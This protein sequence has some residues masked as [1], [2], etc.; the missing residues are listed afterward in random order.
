MSELFTVIAAIAVRTTSIIFVKLT[1]DQMCANSMLRVIHHPSA[2][3]LPAREILEDL[4]SAK[5]YNDM[6]MLARLVSIPP[7]IVAMKY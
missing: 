4:Y 5:M 6:P 1:I 7:L 2:S 3:G